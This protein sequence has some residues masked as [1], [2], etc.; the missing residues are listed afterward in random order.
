MQHV[1][2]ELGNEVLCVEPRE[3]LGEFRRSNEPLRY[4]KG[5]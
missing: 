5:G 4:L 2:I 3:K 1:V